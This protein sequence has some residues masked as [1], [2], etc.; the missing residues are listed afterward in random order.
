MVNGA[1]SLGALVGV[2]LSGG[3]VYWQVGRYATPQVPVTLFDERKEVFAFTAGLFIGVPIQFFLLFLFLAASG[4]FL[5]SAVVDLA[6]V[7]LA[8]QSAQSLLLR[9][10][11]FGGDAKAFYGVGF[12]AGIAGILVLSWVA[13]YLSGPNLSVVG[14]AVVL[15]QSIAIVCL[16]VAASL[17]ALPQGAPLSSIR[18]GPVGG[19]LFAV[20]GLALLVIGSG[21]GT[22]TAAVAALLTAVGAAYAYRARRDTVLAS[23]RPPGAA[24]ATPSTSPFARVDR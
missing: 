24:A 16:S 20:G 1:L 21:L 14:L 6:I 9:T 12:R 8:P 7:V 22:V 13:S 19:A 18:S 23:V 17:V 11:Y 5:I 10:R 15:L 2:L 4:G 3:F